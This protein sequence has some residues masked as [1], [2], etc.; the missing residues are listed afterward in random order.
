V[1]A[2]ARRSHSGNNQPRTDSTPVVL[3]LRRSHYGSFEFESTTGALNEQEN[4]KREPMILR[5]LKNSNNN[6]VTHLGQLCGP[7]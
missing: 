7:F 2:Y 6:R 5:A 4:W 3:K 1:R